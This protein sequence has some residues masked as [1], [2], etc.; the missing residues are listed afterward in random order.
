MIWKNL[1]MEFMYYLIFIFFLDDNKKERGIKERM[2]NVLNWIDGKM[3]YLVNYK[4]LL[5]WKFLF[6]FWR[7]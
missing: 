4:I 3:L 5:I 1:Y 7:N 2:K 6:L